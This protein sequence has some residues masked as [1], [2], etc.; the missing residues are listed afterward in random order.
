M[1]VFGVKNLSFS[2]IRVSYL[3]RAETLRKRGSRVWEAEQAYV[4]Y[5]NRQR[6][7]EHEGDR[8]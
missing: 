3:A 4:F 1:G 8:D 7:A 6:D 2:V 5:W